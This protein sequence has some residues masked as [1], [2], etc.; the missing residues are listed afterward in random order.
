MN[1]R[2]WAKIEVLKQHK[3]KSEEQE[4]ASKAKY[5]PL[6]KAK[7]GEMGVESN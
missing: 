4:E 1:T 5:I 7:L 6:K 2:G 3:Q